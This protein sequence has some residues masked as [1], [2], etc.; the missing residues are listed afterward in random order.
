MKLVSQLKFLWTGNSDLQQCI[1]IECQLQIAR[2][3]SSECGDAPRRRKET[4]PTVLGKL[5]RNLI[6]NW[7]TIPLIAFCSIN[8]FCLPIPKYP[9]IM[10]P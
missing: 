3:L 7:T 10:C 2:E 5:Q 4:L 8:E 9:Q 6:K 1:A